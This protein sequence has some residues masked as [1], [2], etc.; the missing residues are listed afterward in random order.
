MKH[1]G[2]PFLSNIN[3]V[4]S[5]IGIPLLYYILLRYVIPLL[6]EIALLEQTTLLIGMP[7]L[8]I[9]LVILGRDRL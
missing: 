5:L 2:V 7:L 8:S 9:V 3:L 4:L 6:K 1:I